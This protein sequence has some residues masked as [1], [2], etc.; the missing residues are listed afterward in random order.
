MV[1]VVSARRILMAVFLTGS[2][3]TAAWA[4]SPAATV[5]G[6]INGKTIAVRYS[7]PSVRGHRRYEAR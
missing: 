4:Q 5:S 1:R 7:A 2:G 3:A 6:V